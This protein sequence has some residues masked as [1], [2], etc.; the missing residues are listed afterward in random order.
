MV[1]KRIQKLA[2]LFVSYSVNVQPKEKV[3]ITR[4]RSG[5]SAVK[6][7]LQRMFVGGCLSADIG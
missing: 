7:A 5:F 6:R 3:L 4:K 1:D 2:K